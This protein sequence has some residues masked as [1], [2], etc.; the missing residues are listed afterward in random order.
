MDNSPPSATQYEALDLGE[1]EDMS[2]AELRIKHPS[3]GAPT[4]AVVVIAGPEHPQRKRLALGRQRRM[5]AGWQKTGRLQLTDPEEDEADELETLVA[6][7][8]GWRGLMVGGQELQWSPQAARQLYLDPK[9]RYFRDQ[10][11]AGLDERELFIQRSA[12]P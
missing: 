2:S 12:K 6:A 3:T 1:Y 5:R 11:R 7:T 4:A 8:L 10:V 9:R